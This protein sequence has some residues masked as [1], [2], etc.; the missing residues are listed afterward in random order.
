MKKSWAPILYIII[1]FIIIAFPAQLMIMRDV[2]DL[3]CDVVLKG[4]F[5][6]YSVPKMSVSSYYSGEFQK[7]YDQWLNN[8][9]APRG[10]VIK[11]YNQLRY[12]LF[13]EGNRAIGKNGYIFEDPYIYDALCSKPAFDFSRPENAAKMESF[14]ATLQDLSDKL[15]ASGRH[16]IVY[17]TPSKGFYEYDNIP[18]KYLLQEN[19]SGVRAVDLLR[20]LIAET[21]VTYVDSTKILGQETAYPVFYKTGIHWSRTSEEMISSYIAE[22]LQNLNLPVK[23]L[24]LGKVIE[25]KTPFWRDSD[26]YDLLNVIS[27]KTDDM[28]YE[29]ETSSE[30]GNDGDVNILLQGG[31]FAQGFRNSF[32]ENNLGNKLYYINYAN[33]FT[34]KDD[35]KIPIENFDEINLIT[36][37]DSVD[38]VMIEMNESVVNDYTTGFAEWLNNYLDANPLDKPID[39]LTDDYIKKIDFSENIEYNMAALSGYYTFEA[40]QVWTEPESEV[41]LK[42]KAITE[43]GLALNININAILGGSD[44]EY[45]EIYVNGA[46]LREIPLSQIGESEIIIPAEEIAN[47]DDVYSVKMICPISFIPK[48]VTKGSDDARELSIAVMYMGENK[49][50]I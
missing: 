19:K 20:K 49:N 35:K 5:S 12:S 44:K 10:V 22:T 31:S 25:S 23:T 27:G 48:E 8:S 4:N 32:I 16:L 15:E 38:V 14:V 29:F 18:A 45:L 24:Q 34:E 33:Y 9:Y 50:V 41:Q 1:F 2:T 47:D 28:Y 36:Y 43:K 37:L 21:D 6:S 11:L 26:V 39:S 7:S 46:L 17:T 3:D 30:G 40:N 13:S 42:N